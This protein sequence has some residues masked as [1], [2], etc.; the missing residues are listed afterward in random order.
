LYERIGEGFNRKTARLFNG[1]RKGLVRPSTMN[2]AS[3]KLSTTFTEGEPDET[4]VLAFE[5]I[6]ISD[7]SLT[8]SIRKGI[9]LRFLSLG[10]LH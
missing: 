9:L 4:L 3:S 6:G 5:V 7:I 8:S 10:E 2:E 1:L